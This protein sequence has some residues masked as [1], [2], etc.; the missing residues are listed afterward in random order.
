MSEVFLSGSNNVFRSELDCLLR[1]LEWVIRE[2][3]VT[4]EFYQDSESNR[5]W[6]LVKLLAWRHGDI[7]VSAKDLIEIDDRILRENFQELERMKS[8]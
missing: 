5:R 4:V 1:M 6:E 3:H 8:F 2:V 7:R